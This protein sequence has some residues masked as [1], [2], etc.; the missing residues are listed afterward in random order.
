M[1]YILC[2][3]ASLPALRAFLGLEALRTA[4]A[5]ASEALWSE[6]VVWGGGEEGA[7][8]GGSVGGSGGT[9]GEVAMWQ[10]VANR[11]VISLTL[12]PRKAY[13][14][15]GELAMACSE[16]SSTPP[17]PTAYNSIPSALAAACGKVGL[18]VP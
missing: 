11:A 17:K 3:C 1:S 10:K 4:R 13:R 14:L 9:R 12:S 16:L 15:A 5:A 2:F 6:V 7:E 8:E 18:A